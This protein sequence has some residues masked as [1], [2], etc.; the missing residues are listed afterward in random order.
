MQAQ[1]ANQNRSTEIQWSSLSIT[2]HQSESCHPEMLF[3]A[4]VEKWRQYL[5]DACSLEEVHAVALSLPSF[6]RGLYQ[7]TRGDYG[8]TLTVHRVA[9]KW[10]LV[11][12]GDEYLTVSLYNE[13]LAEWF[14]GG[15]AGP[16]GVKLTQ[17]NPERFT[18][19]DLAALLWLGHVMRFPV[20]A[21]WHI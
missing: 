8:T 11:E 12:A 13:S 17:A 10:V 14:R 7:R 21:E 15:E 1:H 18:P 3:P 16:D 20:V 4:L 5:T 2:H 9:G 19:G 6:H